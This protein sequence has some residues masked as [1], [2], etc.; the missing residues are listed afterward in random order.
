MYRSTAAV[1]AS[2]HLFPFTSLDI[3]H[4]SQ[5]QRLS[6]PQ[7]DV[8][9][10]QYPCPLPSIL[11]P[12]RP[13]KKRPLCPH[14]FT[15]FSAG[16]AQSNTI[17]PVVPS[18]NVFTKDL[19][20]PLDV[21]RVSSIGES[22]EQQQQKTYHKSARTVS[23]SYCT[24][25]TASEQPCLHL[26]PTTTPPGA[27]RTHSP[28]AQPHPSPPRARTPAHPIQPSHAGA[29]RARHNQPPPRPAAA[30]SPTSRPHESKATAACCATPTPP[31]S[32]P[33]RA[34]AS[35]STLPAPFRPHLPRQSPV[36]WKR[37]SSSPHPRPPTQV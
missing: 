11:C 12:H 10:T 37:R 34:R 16:A 30:A 3:T 24:T 9:A 21:L 2:L 29:P 33:Q 26:S 25:R 20:A 14:P 6:L 19:L 13:R 18:H 35:N 32:C 28:Q 23:R 31:A 5:L 22:D 17:T 8:K 7:G 15:S 27:A 36:W 4:L 1:T